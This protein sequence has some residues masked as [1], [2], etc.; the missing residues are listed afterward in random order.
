V[1]TTADIRNGLALD[2][3][4][5]AVADWAFRNNHA[6]GR[7]TDTLVSADLL[8]LPLQTPNSVL[9]VMGV[10]LEREHAYHSP[11]NRRLLE[12]CQDALITQGLETLYL[13]VRVSNAPAI[14]LYGACGWRRCGLRSGYYPDGEDAALF[15]Y[16]AP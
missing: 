14:R 5:Q 12:A 4:E 8:Y 9:G 10:R 11:E 3:K 1:A 7:G 15:R 6:A 13:E 2:I 16:Q